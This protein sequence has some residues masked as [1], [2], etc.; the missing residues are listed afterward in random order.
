[1]PC[2]NSVYFTLH[3]EILTPENIISLGDF[4]KKFIA[5]IKISSIINVQKI[6][7]NLNTIIANTIMKKVCS[8]IRISITN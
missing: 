5:D 1:M 6:R 3:K 8:I 2:D 4:V 7:E